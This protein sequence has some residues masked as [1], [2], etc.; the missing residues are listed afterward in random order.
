LRRNG[1]TIEPIGFYVDLRDSGIVASPDPSAAARFW[2]IA[3]IVGS[4]MEGELFNALYRQAGVSTCTV[5]AEANRTRAPVYGLTKA[6]AP[7]LF[8][9]IRLPPSLSDLVAHAVDRGLVAIFPA[10]P[11]VTPTADVWGAEIWDLRTGVGAF[12]ISELAQGGYMPQAGPAAAAISSAVTNPIPNPVSFGTDVEASVAGAGAQLYAKDLAA[13]L[14]QVQAEASNG[15]LNMSDADRL[16]AEASEAPVFIG[17][18]D[19]SK[20]AGFVVPAIQA[21]SDQWTIWTSGASALEKAQASLMS[22][23][24]AGLS[25]VAGSWVMEGVADVAVAFAPETAGGSVVAA[26][27]VIG[28]VAGAQAAVDV[29]STY[30]S[31]LFSK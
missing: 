24:Q 3:G 31:K 23:G 21:A 20:V 10:R 4:V 14:A 8:P 11:V 28:T 27:V 19:A 22:F 6:N 25:Y 7:T 5:L 9:T 18:R 30:L 17:I 26:G 29:V 1:P 16:A 12:W 2:F 15:D 13:Q